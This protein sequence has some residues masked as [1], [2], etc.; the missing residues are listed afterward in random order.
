MREASPRELTAD[1]IAQLLGHGW[2]IER[3]APPK[4]KKPVPADALFITDKR[5]GE[6]LYISGAKPVAID[7]LPDHKFFA[8]KSLPGMR[9]KWSVTEQS[10]GIRL[11]GGDTQKEAIERSNA[12]VRGATPE[13]VI[14]KIAEFDK[15]TDEAKQQ[16][17]DSRDGVV[18]SATENSVPMEDWLSVSELTNVATEAFKKLGHYPAL[19][20]LDTPNDAG[21]S[22][23]D[24]TY[25]GFVR[26]QIVHLV[27][28]GIVSRDDAVDTVWHEI[29]H[30][31]LR[32]FLTR[33]Q[34][35]SD[36]HRLYGRDAFLR[37]KADQWIRND[38]DAQKLRDAGQAEDYIKARGADEALAWFAESIRGNQEF[39]HNSLKA[40]AIR[41]IT[42]WLAEIADFF[43]AARVASQI[44]A[45]TNAEA[46][47][48]V[49]SVFG[50]FSDGSQQVLAWDG[51]RP[52][53]MAASKESGVFKT[54]QRSTMQ[55]AVDTDSAAFREWFGDS[56]VV[57]ADG[58]PLRVYHGTI[59]WEKEDGTQI[60]DIE[61]FDRMASV[62]IV[63][64]GHSIDTVGSWFSTNPDKEGGAGMY[65]DTIYLVYLSIKN[66]HETT[67]QLMTRRA[68]LLANGKDDGRKIGKAEVDAYRKWL[69]DMGKD[70]IRIVHDGRLDATEFAKQDA[71][72]A[73]EPTQIKSAISN[74]G[75]F[76]DTNP[77]ILESRGDAS[78]TPDGTPIVFSDDIGEDPARPHE[79]RLAVERLMHE[80]YA[81]KPAV[82]VTVNT[83]NEVVFVSFASA[84]HILRDGLPDWKT[85]LAVTRMEELMASAIK[86]GSEPDYKGRRDPHSAHY[87]DSDIVI[88]GK[89]H[90]V[91]ITVR[92]HSDGHRYYDHIVVEAKDP[93]G[94]SES[95]AYQSSDRAAPTRPYAR[96]GETVAPHETNGKESRGAKNGVSPSLT[97]STP[98]QIRQSFAK[99]FGE[100]TVRQLEA[101]RM[102]QIVATADDLPLPIT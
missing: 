78:V 59:R 102:I 4:P 66:P 100:K 15:I 33:D 68:R 20:I 23:G 43:G 46:R 12:N 87:Y 101:K 45:M 90:A 62:N 34:Y 50:K 72:I 98:E 22:A 53:F 37:L 36:M 28:D 63:R 60:G 49:M 73:L 94:Q 64:R 8:H 26:N 95:S 83:T 21:V 39:I 14:N 30:F 58:N 97:R 70:G 92:E 51:D 5:S 85:A 2:T 61:A 82:P 47:Q 19:K 80:K 65:G 93:A 55:A 52:T 35:I 1:A 67:F 9:D 48:Y 7:G 79:Y 32:R 10:T 71:W 89:L 57:D 69:A 91:H 74:T 13:V 25:A 86:T 81:G 99:A 17:W 88:D 3:T 40:K 56:K 27:R 96:S 18:A 42:R 76:S 24:R 44:R 54:D 77:S 11:A 16:A 31:G 6:T 41:T 38:P 84:K 75:E 29:F